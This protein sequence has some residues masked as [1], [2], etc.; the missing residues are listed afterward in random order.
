MYVTE[1]GAAFSD[2]RSHDGQVRDPERSDF[3]AQYTTAVRQAIEA[4]APV[5]G[6]FVWSLLDNFE[7]AYGYAKRFGIVFVDYP[8]L[9]RTPKGSFH[10]YREFIAAQRAQAAAAA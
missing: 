5:R 9:E 6:Y 8:T 4:G 3:L 10:W 2:H 1:N 7:W